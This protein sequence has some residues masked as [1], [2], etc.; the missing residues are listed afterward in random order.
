[1]RLPVVLDA[2][3]IPAAEL[4]ALRLDGDCFA[5]GD[6]F[7]ATDQPVDAAVR[8]GS[9][10]GEARRHGLVAELWTAAWV[11]GVVPVLPRPHLLSIDVRRTERTRLRPGT[12][13]VRFAD[14]EVLVLGGMRVTSPLRTAGDLARLERV[15]TAELTR[16]LVA[17]LDLAG[18]TP[19]VAAALLAETPP[20]PYKRR[21]LARIRG[22]G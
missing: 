6:A 9:I 22:L 5:I 21:G 1:M 14:G 20:S 2:P 17:L 3:L 11:H 19:E 15:E 10:A 4:A 7:V 8:A 18:T 12:R 16:V 13:E